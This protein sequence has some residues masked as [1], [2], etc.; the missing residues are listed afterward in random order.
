MATPDTVLSS[1]PSLTFAHGSLRP[2]ERGRLE[3]R[4]A[5]I[6]DYE[7]PKWRSSHA[8]DVSGEHTEVPMVDHANIVFIGPVGSGK[9]SLIG[10]LWRAVNQDTVFPDRI[11]LTLNHPDE[12]THGTMKW[13]ET[14]GNKKRTIIYQDTRGDQEYDTSERNVHEFSLRGMYRDGA[15]LQSHSV[16]SSDWWISRRFFWERGQGEVP[17][18]VVFVFDGSSDPFLDAES[19]EFFKTVFED[20]TKLGYEPVIVVSCLD[21]IYQEALRVGENYEVQIQHKRDHILQAFEN[22]NLTRQSIY[23]VTNFHEG[24]R[25]GVRVWEAGDK[26]F[27]R[28]TKMLVDLGRDLLTVADRFIERKYTGNPKCT[29]L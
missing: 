6:Q 10:S 3:T 9:S 13:M 26:G 8:D 17:H 23:F 25:G 4:R 14:C 29:V 5:H 28:A 18:C 11:Q 19:M 16:F 20:C 22:L 21:L 27:E 12:D 15:Q 1:Y 2:E 7:P 24:K